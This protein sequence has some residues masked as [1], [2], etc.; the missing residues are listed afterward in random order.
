M[1][2]FFCNCFSVKISKFY[3]WSKTMKKIVLTA[4][5]VFGLTGVANTV[6]AMPV[7]GDWVTITEG[8][9]SLTNGGEFNIAINGSQES[10][11]SFC[12]EYTENININTSNN[13]YRIGSVADYATNGGAGAIED[14]DGSVTGTPGTT[15]DPVSDESKWLIWNYLNGSFNF[16]GQVIRRGYTG[17]DKIYPRNHLV[18]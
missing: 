11:I 18:L 6:V 1:L 7:A 8:E 15:Y 17:L 2:K 13:T 16:N 14:G 12:L 9:Y 3:E 4:A 5:L 10:Y